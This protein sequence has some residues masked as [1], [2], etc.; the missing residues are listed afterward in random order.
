METF[1]A[2]RERTGAVD[3]HIQVW[4]TGERD[5]VWGNEK[6]QED[7]S[8]SADWLVRSQ[9]LSEMCNGSEEDSYLSL[10]EFCI[11]QLLAG[12]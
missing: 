7:L 11:T 6:R 2:G 8:W 12:E 1:R 10:I 3:C 9:Y 5:W 4:G